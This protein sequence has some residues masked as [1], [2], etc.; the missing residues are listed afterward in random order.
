MDTKRFKKND[1]GFIC[2]NCGKEVLPLGY[3]SRN[4][5][6]H[7]LSSLHVDVFPGD[8]ANECRG[9]M[10][11]VAVELSAKKGFVISHRCT[12]CGFVGKNKAADDDDRDK[13]IELTNAYNRK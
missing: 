4:H 9:L 10:E 1:N 11:A 6:P 13:L 5:C 7:C 3:T 8:R 12:K 2:L